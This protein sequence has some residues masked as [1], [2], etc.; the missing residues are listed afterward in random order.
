MGKA[1]PAVIAWGAGVLGNA[2][3]WT[4]PHPSPARKNSSFRRPR[5][6]RLA[7][8]CAARTKAH[9]KASCASPFQAEASHSAIWAAACLLFL[10]SRVTRVQYLK[11]VAGAARRLFIV[12]DPLHSLALHV[13]MTQPGFDLIR[14]LQFSTV[15]ELTDWVDAMFRVDYLTTAVR[16]KELPEAYRTVYEEVLDLLT[17]EMLVN[18]APITLPRLLPIVEILREKLKNRDLDPDNVSMPPPIMPLP[19][20]PTSLFRKQRLDEDLVELRRLEAEADVCRAKHH[21]RVLGGQESRG[22]RGGG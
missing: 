21:L 10:P 1:R 11:A 17:T 12:L 15:V 22:G 18:P 2:P 8:P 5:S 9:T 6:Q 16:S 13:V 20:T 7:W 19:S 4:I 3:G 14:S